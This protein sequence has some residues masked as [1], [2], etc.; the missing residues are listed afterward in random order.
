MTDGNGRG[1]ADFRVTLEA[2]MK[3]IAAPL[4]AH[5]LNIWVEF[6]SSY[7]DCRPFR[8]TFPHILDNTFWSPTIH[9]TQNNRRKFSH[10]LCL[11]LYT[12]TL[13]ISFFTAKNKLIQTVSV[14][15]VVEIWSS[16]RERNLC[17]R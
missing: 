6:V 9:F 5:N 3:S 15:T 17:I 16:N 12:S 13:H 2:G 8:T 10:V 14:S 11:I 1:R 7:V 4:L